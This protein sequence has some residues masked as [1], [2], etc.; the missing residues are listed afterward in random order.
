MC[1]TPGCTFVN[2]ETTISYYCTV[3]GIPA[4]YSATYYNWS[5]FGGGSNPIDGPAYADIN[6]NNSPNSTL[7]RVEVTVTLSKTNYPPIYASHS[8]IVTVKYIGPLT[9]M[10]IPGATPS[11]PGNGS[12]T[13]FPCGVQ[14]VNISVNTPVTDPVQP[15]TYSWSYPSGWT[16]PATTSTPSA[17]AT[18]S[19]GQADGSLSVSAR[20]TDGT[21]VQSYSVY[22][23]RPRVGTPTITPSDEPTL[24]TTSQTVNLSGSATNATTWNWTASG[25]AIVFSGGSS[26]TATI[27]ATS[28]GSVTV[29][30]NNACQSPRI[31]SK[32]IYFGPATLSSNKVN[33]VPAQPVNYINNPAQLSSSTIYP[34]TTFNWS[35]DGGT[36]SIYPNGPNC[37]AY[38]Y[39]FVRVK[40]QT[41]N[42][43]GLGQ[44]YIYYL[45]LNGSSFQVI[46]PNPVE[47]MVTIQFKDLDIARTYLEGIELS[48]ASQRGLRRFDGLKARGEKYFDKTDLVNFEVKDLAPGYYYLTVQIAGQKFGET[49][50]KK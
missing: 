37:L 39:P 48:S 4:G 29:T 35:V 14:N 42:I 16:G 6:W 13:S 5:S 30:A 44:S 23:T 31:A 8:L 15:V 40:V 45:Y 3:T 19:A 38:A 7:K 34:S 41:N 25:G 46:S 43:C 11:N 27:K 32:N 28:N 1:S 20:R 21:K 49:L 26:S 22:I 18:S 10:S 47:D 2:P 12:S 24:C 50:I 33:G 9:Q 17:T 36:G